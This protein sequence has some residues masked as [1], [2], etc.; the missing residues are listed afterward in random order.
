MQGVQQHVTTTNGEWKEEKGRG[1]CS[2]GSLSSRGK[3]GYTSPPR[4]RKMS[5]CRKKLGV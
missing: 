2:V 5:A 3:S 4:R 1:R